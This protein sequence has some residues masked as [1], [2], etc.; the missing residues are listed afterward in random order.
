VIYV[1]KRY[2]LQILSPLS[3]FIQKEEIRKKKVIH[4]ARQKKTDKTKEKKKEEGRN[5]I[6]RQPYER[7]EDKTP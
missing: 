7:L 3:K 2:L 4:F 1:G 6:A 5:M